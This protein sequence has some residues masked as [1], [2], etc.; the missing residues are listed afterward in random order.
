MAHHKIWLLAVTSENEI[1][2][3]SKESTYIKIF[4]MGDRRKDIIYSQVGALKYVVSLRI[5]KT[6]TFC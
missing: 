4:G 6:N 5:H 2:G 1:I 3:P